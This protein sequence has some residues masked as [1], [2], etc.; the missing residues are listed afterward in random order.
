M[1]IVTFVPAL[2]PTLAILG[3]LVLSS[4]FLPVAFLGGMTGT[5]YKQ[6]AV[7]I[8]I[9]VAI[10]G[11]VALTL[12]P[13]LAALVLKPGSHEKKGFFRWRRILSSKTAWF[14]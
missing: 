6:F 8:A 2:S 7:T 12:S 13:M 1:A 4:V 5:L 14:M 9:S 3:I 10:S 11:L